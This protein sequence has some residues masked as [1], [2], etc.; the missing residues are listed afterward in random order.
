MSKSIRVPDTSYRQ[1]DE[2]RQ[3]GFESLTNVMAVA[4]D[5]LYQAEMPK[6]AEMRIR[7]EYSADSVDDMD[8]LSREQIAEYGDSLAA[9]IATEYPNAEVEVTLGI[10]NVVRVYCDDYAV[11]ERTGNDVQ[12]L[13]ADHWQ[14]W[15]DNVAMQLPTE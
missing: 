15:I 13:I 9:H 8:V 1:A 12:Q 4:I 2:L 6:E 5:R 10:G 3:H 14:P 11:M 7:V